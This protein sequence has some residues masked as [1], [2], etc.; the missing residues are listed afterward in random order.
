MYLIL[1]TSRLLQFYTV[2]NYIKVKFETLEALAQFCK[3][4]IKEGYAIDT[5]SLTLKAPLSERQKAIA[6]KQFAAK[7]LCPCTRLAVS[8]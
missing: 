6:Q 8:G 4:I 1:C 7:V 2:M 5:T 3:M